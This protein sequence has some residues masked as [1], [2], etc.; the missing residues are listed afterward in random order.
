MIALVPLAPALLA[1]ALSG[2][3]AGEISDCADAECRRAHLLAAWDGQPESVATDLAQITEPVERVAVITALV[4]ARPEEARALCGA[5]PR[6]DDARR[7]CERM[8]TRPHLWQARAPAAAD[9]SPWASIAPLERVCTHAVD[10]P[11]C[12]A[13]VAARAA[14]RGDS[15]K[16]AAACNAEQTDVWRWE[17]FFRA[18]EARAAP[19]RMSA[20]AEG[21]ELCRA[22]GPFE[23]NCQRHLVH[24]ATIY[25]PPATVDAP[26]A[27]LLQLDIAANIERYWAGRDPETGAGLVGQLWSEA[28]EVS[29]QRADRVVGNPL[30]PLPPSALPHARAAAAWRLLVLEALSEEGPENVPTLAALVDRLE[31]ALATRVRG[32]PSFAPGPEPAS[33]RDLWVDDPGVPSVIYRGTSRRVV[34]EEPRADLAICVLEAAARAAPPRRALLAEGAG[35]PQALVRATAERLLGL[36]V[37]CAGCAPCP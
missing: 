18:A 22:A 10:R 28:L 3:G 4:E 33:V 8:T 15:R 36:V 14:T 12:L 1:V 29:Y 13:A 37:P 7:R 25:A 23:D 35:H 21:A 6:G 24:R 26:D 11:V 2:C 30:L 32:P 31:A 19:P 16:A 34:A 5:L 17:C 27:W 20:Y 9:T